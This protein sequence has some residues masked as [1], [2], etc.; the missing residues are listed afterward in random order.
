M[1][2]KIK[3]LLIT[4]EYLKSI[5]EYNPDTGIFTWNKSPNWSICV[6]DVAGCLNQ[7]YISIKIDKKRYLAHRLAWLYMTG[8]WPEFEIDHI[9]GIN[10][11]NFNKFSNL[12]DVNHNNNMLN[13]EKYKSNT[14]GYRGVSWDNKSKKWRSRIGLNKK[15]NLLGYFNTPEEA[16]KAYEDAKIKY[17]IIMEES[18]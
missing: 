12:R 6:G 2:N 1:G 5:L 3:E 13:K 15:T 11:P 14:S 9:E 7:G 8:S 16:S 18:L 17:H 4:Q 10:I